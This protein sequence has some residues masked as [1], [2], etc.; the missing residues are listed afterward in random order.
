[1]AAQLKHLVMPKYCSRAANGLSRFRTV[2]PSIFEA[3]SGP[4][5]DYVAFQ[6]GHCGYDR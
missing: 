3:R 4:L 6:F 5:S 1:L 2:P